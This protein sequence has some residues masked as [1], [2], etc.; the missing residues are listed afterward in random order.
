MTY[1]LEA[2][3][4]DFP[5][6]ERCIYFNHASVGP[7]SR[8]VRQAMDRHSQ[9]HVECIDTVTQESEPVR[10]KGRS[11]AAKLV[12]SK[13]QR[14][15]YIQNTSHGL[16]LI[17]H[18]IDWQPGDNVV[19]PAMEFP[20]NYL[21]WKSLESKGVSLR[22]WPLKDGRLR[23]EDLEP[24]VDSR[25][26]VVTLSQVQYHNGFKCDLASISAICH[27]HNA[28]FVVDGTQ[29]VGAVAV[30]VDSDGI[31]ALVVSAH[32]WLLGPFGIGF[33]ALSDRAFDQLKVAVLGWYSVNEPFE[34]RRELDLLPTAERFEPGTKNDVGIFGMTTR[35]EEIHELGLNAIESWILNLNDRLATAIKA[36]G[37]VVT[38]PWGRSERSGILTLT[39]RLIPSETLLEHL[40]AATI[41]ASVRG[42]ALRI[43]PH[44]YNSESEIE[45]LAN[46]LPD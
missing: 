24:L 22:L 17:A 21:I 41:K 14:I 31:D 20:S 44:Y 42:G 28:L 12:G 37:Y 38:S 10:S 3:R 2:I 46:A 15:A 9:L 6:V 39:H 32:K 27:S 25:T 35:L 26:R 23:A 4:R 19:V 30:D 5:V 1:N 8:R 40:Q 29:S 13:P 11:L 45:I 33:M 16:S 18:G 43:S 36:K 7:I 34:F